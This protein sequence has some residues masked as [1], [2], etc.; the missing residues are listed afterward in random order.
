VSDANIVG[1]YHQAWTH[2][3]LDTARSCL[4]DDLDFQGP[5]D[6]FTNADDLIGALTQ[7][8][9]MCKRVDVLQE[10]H[11]DDAAALLYDCVTESPAGTIRTAEFFGLRDGKIASIRLVFDATA[12]RQA[13]SR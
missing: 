9:Q 1:K 7:F 10:F 3:D 8:A 13:M 6:T 2:R 5:I 4:A 11:A 12:L